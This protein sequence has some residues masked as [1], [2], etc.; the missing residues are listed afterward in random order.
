MSGLLEYV[1]GSSTT[2]LLVASTRQVAER[3]TPSECSF[4]TSS[5]RSLALLVITMFVAAVEIAHGQRCPNPSQPL[6][7]SRREERSAYG[8][9]EGLS[10]YVQADR[11]AGHVRAW[12][13]SGSK[14]HGGRRLQWRASI[15]AFASVTGI[16]LGVTAI[17]VARQAMPR[18][19]RY[20]YNL[21]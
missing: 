7:D 9:S 15:F 1:P 10:I 16:S 17:L 4:F 3:H 5:L 8:A 11:H 13:Q 2:E 21:T 12:G 20:V 18:L 14:M 6:E 19:R